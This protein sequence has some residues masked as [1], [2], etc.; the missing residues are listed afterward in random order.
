VQIEKGEMM[1]KLVR[2][3]M[4]EFLEDKG[5][6]IKYVKAPEEERDQLLFSKLIEELLEWMTAEGRENRLKELGDMQEV[7]WA[8]GS[9]EGIEATEILQQAHGKNKARGGFEKLIVM[10]VELDSDNLKVPNI[11][12]SITPVD[13]PLGDGPWYSG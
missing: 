5:A 12:S 10:T 3:K 9:M 2:D 8:M 11:I 13:R 7:I 1:R 6:E 4:E